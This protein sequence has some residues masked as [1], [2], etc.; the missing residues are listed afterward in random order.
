MTG[1]PISGNLSGLEIGCISG[2]G[3]HPDESRDTG[4]TGAISPDIRGWK[5][6]FL[7]RYG[8]EKFMTGG[9]H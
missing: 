7:D 8:P 1:P 9:V 6:R 5:K 3:S 2:K 4:T